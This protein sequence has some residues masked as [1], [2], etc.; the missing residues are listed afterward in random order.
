MLS[1][2]DFFSEFAFRRIVVGTS[3]I[4]ATAGAM[5]TFL[6]LRRQ[7]MMSDVIGHAATPG[8]M[9]AFLLVSTLLPGADARSMPFLTIGAVITGLIAALLANAIARTTRIGIDATMAAMLS[10]FLGGGFVLLNVIQNSHISGKGSVAELM[11]GNAASLTNLD[12]TTIAIAAAIVFVI[13]VVFWRPFVTMTFDPVLGHITGLKMR[14]YDPLLFG[15]IVLSIILGIKAVGL[16][17]MVAFA[18]FPPA[19][20]RQ[21]TR[22]VGSMTVVSAAIGAV[23]GVLGSYLSVAAGK[24][25]T[26][27]VIVLVLGAFVLVASVFSHRRQG[28]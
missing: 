5:G 9:A 20:A 6:Y 15:T 18:I 26:G 24:V 23:S 25:P 4:G 19:A 7:S 17:L 14:V 12:V 2:I 13:V 10:F 11:F 3:L 8:V 21:W 16:I 22:T 28:V 27:P 1:I